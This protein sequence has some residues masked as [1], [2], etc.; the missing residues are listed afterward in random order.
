[1]FDLG[2]GRGGCEVAEVELERYVFGGRLGAS[3]VEIDETE[4]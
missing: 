4:G 1:M 2:G 3:G